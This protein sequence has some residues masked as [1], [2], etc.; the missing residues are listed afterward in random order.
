MDVVEAPTVDG[1]YYFNTVYVGNKE[2]FMKPYN[3]MIEMWCRDV[4]RDLMELSNVKI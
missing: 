3:A 4:N 1:K 2:A